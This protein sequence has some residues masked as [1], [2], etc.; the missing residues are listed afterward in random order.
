[1]MVVMMIVVGLRVFYQFE[2]AFQKFTGRFPGFHLRCGNI[3]IYPGLTQDL[4]TVAAQPAH[5]N[6]R[7]PLLQHDFRKSSRMMLGSGKN[8]AR[9]NLLIFH[10]SK[11]KTVAVAHMLAD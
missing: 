3:Y 6:I 2:L 7:S 8:I 1:M 9:Y 4:Q 10:F 5:Q 11:P